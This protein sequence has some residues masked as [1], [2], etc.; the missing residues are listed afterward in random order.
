MFKAVF[1]EIRVIYCVTNLYVC[2]D[3]FKYIR[4]T[5]LTVRSDIYTVIMA[6]QH[7]KHI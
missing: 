4:T 6:L 5:I 3:M 1:V 2:V 7:Y